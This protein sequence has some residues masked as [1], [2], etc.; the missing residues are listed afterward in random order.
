MHRHDF[1]ALKIA[2][3]R[4]LWDS[5]EREGGE[6][7]GCSFTLEK[8]LE[9]KSSFGGCSFFFSLYAVVIP[10]SR[11]ECFAAVSG[12]LCFVN[13][14]VVTP[15]ALRTKIRAAVPQAGTC[16]CGD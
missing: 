16:L 4:L 5:I 14:V 8:R 1:T 6:P 3:I 11:E 7:L 13:D 15:G 10:C 2:Q 12:S 9:N